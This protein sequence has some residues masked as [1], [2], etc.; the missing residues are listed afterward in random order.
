[1]EQTIR[2]IVVGGVNFGESDRMV[3]L[4]TD[5]GQCT[6]S[7]PKARLSRRRFGGGLVPFNTIDAEISPKKREIRVLNS[8][9]VVVSRF[10]L[11]ASFQK[12]A[13]ASYVSELGWRVG[14]EGVPTGLVHLLG[15]C[16]D[17]LLHE[18]SPI[19]VRAFQLKLLDELGHRP[20]LDRCVRCAKPGQFLDLV[21]GGVFC[22]EHRTPDSKQIGPRTI[23]WMSTCLDSTEFQYMCGFSASD[24]ERIARIL[25]RPLDRTVE[26]L[27]GRSLK[28][29]TLLRQALDTAR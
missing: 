19:I 17:S 29:T 27:V 6:L 24:A 7:A 25:D 18:Q 22:A 13:M 15:A 1:M 12:L 28:S 2:G 8:V 21:Q 20:S 5:L 9:S 16:L 10:L 4:L 11:T 23:E 26:W 14:K 3:Y